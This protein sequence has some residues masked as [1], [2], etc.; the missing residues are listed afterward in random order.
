MDTRPWFK[1]V[2]AVRTY[3]CS[4]NLCMQIYGSDLEDVVLFQIQ[5]SFPSPK[6]PEFQIKHIWYDSPKHVL[7]VLSASTLG[8]SDVISFTWQRWSLKSLGD[9]SE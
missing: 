9:P 7:L 8:A 5:Q 6:K 4:A 2:S 1:A 3:N